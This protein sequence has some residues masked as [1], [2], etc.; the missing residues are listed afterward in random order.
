M[1]KITFFIPCLYSEYSP[2]TAWYGTIDQKNGKVG[3]THA[4]TN[5][6][7]LGLVMYYF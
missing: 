3:N 5:H 7:I 4:I 6:R 2:A 1:N